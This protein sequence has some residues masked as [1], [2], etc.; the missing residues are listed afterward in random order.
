MRVASGRGIRMAPVALR[1]HL[2]GEAP[3]CTGVFEVLDED[4]RTLDIDMAG[5]RTTFGLR[6]ALLDWL[7][8]HGGRYAWSVRWESA[9]VYL[10]RYHE[11]LMDHIARVGSLPPMT[12]ARGERAPGR[13]TPR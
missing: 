1:E 4:G 9:T 11:L 3:V 5:A 7:R 10:P 8:E 12:I 6:G 13:L 2:V